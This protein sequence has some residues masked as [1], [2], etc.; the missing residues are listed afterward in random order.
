MLTSISD[1]TSHSSL[2]AASRTDAAAFGQE[3]DGALLA[4]TNQDQMDTTQVFNDVYAAFSRNMSP[5][6]AQELRS[7][8]AR[9]TRTTSWTETEQ[10]PNAKEQKYALAKLVASL[11]D[12]KDGSYGGYSV[13]GERRGQ[14]ATL[15]NTLHGILS[16][17]Y[18][19]RALSDNQFNNFAADR[20]RR[21]SDRP[22]APEYAAGAYQTHDEV[23][24]RTAVVFRLSDFQGTSP[25]LYA[26]GAFVHEANHAVYAGTGV[27]RNH[28]WSMIVEEFR[29]YSSTDYLSGESRTSMIFLR[30]LRYGD[31]EAR[32]VYPDLAEAVERDA[33]LRGVIDRF[34]V[35]ADE[36]PSQ[37]TAD[38]LAQMMR[39]SIDD[40][41]PLDSRRRALPFLRLPQRIDN[42][43]P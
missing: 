35:L 33:R 31:Q 5:A 43:A 18:V 34:L 32:E 38:R 26:V 4:S 24:D 19:V 7:C 20:S 12:A 29:A 13:Y 1:Q 39:D 2:G 28:A 10:F 11:V 36:D 3:V 16:G 30:E 17:E 25:D 40:T 42:R 21:P 14:L 22:G 41:L 6:Q 37:C 8:L 27:D 9:L 23:L 15:N